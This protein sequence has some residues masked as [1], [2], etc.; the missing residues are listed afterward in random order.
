MLRTVLNIHWRVKSTNTRLYGKLRPV[1]QNIAS[2]W[3]KR[4]EHCKCHPEEVAAS[5]ITLYYSSHLKIRQTGAGIFLVHW[6]TIR[7]CWHQEN[8]Q[9]QMEMTGWDISWR[10]HTESMVFLGF[11]PLKNFFFIPTKP[12]GFSQAQSTCWSIQL[13][14]SNMPIQ[15]QNWSLQEICWNPYVRWGGKTLA[16]VYGY[17][18]CF[19]KP[20]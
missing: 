19:I 14:R 18:Y 15:A 1:I 10:N 16:Y 5:L 7:A 11:S 6:C 9:T 2:R 12:Q 3:L 13:E 4:A 8:G 17:K 20:E